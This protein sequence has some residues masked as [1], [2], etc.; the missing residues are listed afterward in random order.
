MTPDRSRQ[1]KKNEVP[2]QNENRQKDVYLSTRRQMLKMKLLANGW[3]S[4]ARELDTNEISRKITEGVAAVFG[5]PKVSLYTLQEDHLVLQRQIGYEDIPDVISLN[6]SVE[7]QVIHS[8]I[9]MLV[10]EFPESRGGENPN[11]KSGSKLYIPLFDED[12]VIGL[13]N[14]ET[15]HGRH[16]TKEDLSLMDA[17]GGYIS[18]AFWRA[19][20]NVESL[21]TQQALDAERRLLRTVIDNIPD[22]IFARDRECRFTLSNLSDA[23][24]MGVSNPDQ[25]LGKNDLDF[26]PPELA[27]RYIED[28]KKVIES[29][30]PLINIIE[31]SSDQQGN[32]RWTMTTKVPLHDNQDQIIGLVGIAR[33]ITLERKN[34]QALEEAKL[35]AEEANRA[36]SSFLA[37]MSHEIRTPLNAILG[38]SQLLLRE[39]DLT[40][41]QRHQLTTIHN[42]GEHLLQLINDIL[43]ISKIEAGRSTLNI[44]PFDLYTLMQDLKSMFQVRT[45]EKHLSFDVIFEDRVP[46]FVISDES[47]LRQILINLIGNAVKFTRQGRVRCI[48]DAV[49]LEEDNWQLT[50]QVEDSGIGITAEDINKLFQ[51]F[52]QAPG[53][54]SEGGTGLGLAISQRFARMLNGQIS[55]SSEPG[56]GSCFS[57]EITVQEDRQTRLER[58]KPLLKIK[59]IKNSTSGYRILVV[60]DVKDSRE[61]LYSLLSQVGFDIREAANG[62]EGLDVWKSWSPHLIIMDI[63]MP[64]MNGLDATRMIRNSETNSHI[65]IIAAT[66]S[67]F[68]EEKQT[69]LDAGM[70]G[71]LRKPIQEQDLFELVGSCLG[72]E[73]TYYSDQEMQ[74]RRSKASE[75]S[76]A[77]SE[78]ISSIPGEIRTRIL[79]ACSNA[80]L[81][82]LL[83]TLEQIADD[84][85][86]IYTQ[87]QDLAE[88]LQY[89]EIIALV[90]A[91]S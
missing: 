71:Y 62:I 56:V 52:Q 74:D 2:S 11:L 61:L 91:R 85:P 90:E 20:I 26:Y 77:I 43:E 86:N 42:S 69:I 64:V 25:L 80:D 37:N 15:N 12:T 30:Q 45:D 5:Y 48:V 41:Q 17:I 34:A 83:E 49:P 82:A 65:P 81:D 35:Q 63:R 27:M 79:T 84:R 70:N 32:E 78:E 73:F 59:R 60:D 58:K 18:N 51:V 22:Q 1:S 39:P 9:S 21:Q 68:E 23:Q 38:F 6:A 88:K 40:I 46:R 8:G 31:P 76:P 53:G 19:R 28:D 57:L 54:I 14:V 29:G 47:K 16:L 4:I 75:T 89:G 44:A 55:V 33:D 10:K 50:I 24:I 36:K 87:L 72:L 3:N 13:F 67:A 66:A 7:G